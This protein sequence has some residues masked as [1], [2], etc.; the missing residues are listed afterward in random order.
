MHSVRSDQR[1]ARTW[2]W[3]GIVAV[4]LIVLVA[5]QSG[6]G[7]QAL[8]G[9]GLAAEPAV[10]TELYFDPDVALPASLDPIRPTEVP[11]AFFVGN[12]AGSP[13]DVPW[14]IVDNSSGSPI[15][16]AE[17]VADGLGSQQRRSESVSVPLVCGTQA[18]DLTVRIPG[19]TVEI[20]KRILC[21]PADKSSVRGG[22]GT[23]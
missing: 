12:V 5:A 20:R 6:P 19:E 1:S 15:V 18:F 9:L 3:V 17:G 23:G 4:V 16:R 10:R 22:R 21:G 13:R 7:H 8:V 11:V 14:E 2:V